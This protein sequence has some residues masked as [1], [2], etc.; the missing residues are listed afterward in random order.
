[1]Q[2]STNSSSRGS[3]SRNLV[4][5]A[6]A[7]AAV[8]KNALRPKHLPKLQNYALTCLNAHILSMVLKKTKSGS[9]CFGLNGYLKSLLRAS[10]IEDLA[11]LINSAEFRD[12]LVEG[13][14]GK[15]R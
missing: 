12:A 5:T 9:F 11:T 2:Q 4:G 10:P 3:S 6:A 14:N 8:E 7:F 15:A 13:C 1:M